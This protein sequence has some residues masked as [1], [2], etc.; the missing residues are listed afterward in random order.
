MKF[1]D[2]TFGKKTTLELRYTA[3]AGTL[4]RSGDPVDIRHG[5]S[6]DEIIIRSANGELRVTPADERN[7]MFLDKIFGSACYRLCR[8]VATPKG[9]LILAVHEFPDE[10][11]LSE[12][13][14]IGV[15]EKVI[16]LARQKKQSYTKVEEV[17]DWLND[18]LVLT[19]EDSNDRYVFLTGTPGNQ[20]KLSSAF[21]LL[22]RTVSVDVKTDKT[23]RLQ[24]ERVVYAQKNFSAA[25]AQS[26]H[27]VRGSIQFIDG[28]SAQEFRGLAKDLIEQVVQGGESYLALWNRYNE[29]ERKIRIAEAREFGVFPY[30]SIKV[31]NDGN[32][33]FTLC[34]SSESDS[35]R[36]IGDAGEAY[37]EA[38]SHPPTE[39]LSQSEEN[40]DTQQRSQRSFMGTTES[41]RG[42]KVTLKPSDEDPVEPPP[43]GSLFLSIRGDTARLKRRDDAQKRII[44][45][46][47]PMP[48]LGLILEGRHTPEHRIK[49]EEPL[50]PAAKKAFRGEPTGRQIEA[51]DA[52]LNTPDIVLIQGPPG[53]GKTR[54]IA[55]LQSRLAE[56]H[57]DHSLVSGRILLTS[58]QH[59]AVENVAEA[60][61]IFGLPA[62]K[63]GN[64]RDR[65]TGTDGFLRWLEDRREAV[66]GQLSVVPKKSISPVIDK[67]NRLESG[68]RQSS[69]AYDDL[70]SLLKELE[71]LASP[72]MAEPS[73]DHLIKLK[74]S[75][76]ALGRNQEA[77]PEKVSLALKAV[78]GLRTEAGSFS[79][80]GPDQAYKALKRLNEFGELEG[81]AL[82][83]LEK[84][85]DFE[86]GDIPEPDELEQLKRLQEHWIDRLLIHESGK[87]I[88][89][90][91]N[92]EIVTLFQSIKTDL[93]KRLALDPDEG[94]DA[95]LHEY[96]VDL[97]NEPTMRRTIEH[98]STALAAT[99][100]QAVG[101]E[102]ID[103][104]GETDTWPTFEYVIVDEAARANPLDL[105]IPMSLAERKIVLV[106]DHRQ[107]P[108]ILETEIENEMETAMEGSSMREKANEI[109]R[110][111][112]FERL[113]KL[114]KERVASDGKARTVTLNQQFR[115]HPMLGQ[116]VSDTFYEP[117][118][119]GFKSGR[120]AEEMSHEIEPYV[121]TPAVWVNLPRRNGSELKGMSKARPVEAK[122]VANEAVRIMEA[123]PYLSVGVITFYRKQVDLIHEELERH[124]AV[125]R[126]EN[127]QIAISQSYRQTRDV[128]SGKLKERLRIGTVD[129]FQGK[130]FDVVLLSIVRSNDISATE[131]IQNLRRKYGHLILE[132][133]LCVG[134][135][136]QQRLLI[137]CGDSGMLDGKS[138]Q[139]AIPGLI[140]FHKLCKDQGKV[141]HA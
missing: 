117:H 59:D 73:K 14:S 1:E 17:V 22:G 106:G 123:H 126:G 41:S 36:T 133:R 101:N 82:Q 23:G 113:F 28:T 87:Q 8:I 97:N 21:R 75:I 139:E 37:L 13:V 51:L 89:S 24:V 76:D 49:R 2:L 40:P 62:I 18:E 112:L 130:E 27:L 34:D 107:L 70:G 104:K 98:Y 95:A 43:Q 46:K 115:M 44:E 69:S 72:Y 47:C 39:F 108:H 9:R 15:D 81:E 58:Y 54:V 6:N 29:I 64:K 132:N 74:G 79:D 3:N 129:A 48:Q 19:R 31:L 56:I 138:A 63:I 111:S 42:K 77:L 94:A 67:V 10:L 52:A 88:K 125:E 20:N 71:C 92:T 45:G 86:P 93:R 30:E 128:E 38:A 16:D 96:R 7:S 124:G 131:D 137:V 110:E 32:Y 50:S 90:R 65:S 103:L 141:T 120:K 121:G 135:S 114:M 134:M 80:D 140:A 60:T 5:E 105:L 57:G 84:L 25:N 122:W 68:Y 85:A 100:Q 116:F 118:G 99:C 12:M 91:Q 102:M 26:V 119:E 83:L 109:L 127:G 53:T 78:R 4:P 33:E 35:T 61:E 66:D 11:F 55:A 136:R